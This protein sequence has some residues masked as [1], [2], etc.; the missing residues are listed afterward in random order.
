MS[1]QEYLTNE[2][3][4]ITFDK[5]RTAVVAKWIV[6]P[7][8][9]EFRE[10]LDAM[11]AAMKKFV[12]GKLVVDTTHL[13]AIHEDDQKWAATDWYNAARQAGYHRIAM[14]V[15]SNI[16]TQMSVEST[17]ESVKESVINTHHFDSINAA[18]E[19]I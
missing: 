3:I 4:E 17:I 5:T 12:T 2:F 8:S 9:I 7:T 14:V 1:T 18:L 6:S 16:F 11:V 15:P 10:G 13:G 19:W